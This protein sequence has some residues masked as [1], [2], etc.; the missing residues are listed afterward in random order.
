MVRERQEVARYL[1]KRGCKTDILMAAALGDIE[2]VREHLDTDPKC[3]G[4]NVSERYFTKRDPRAGGTIYIWCLGWNKTAHLVAR[5]F[6]HEEIFGLLM[7]RSP[8]ELKLA[9]ACELGD[10]A[11]F[12]SLMQSR[13]RLVETLSANE[14][15]K[16][17]NAAQS[18][19]TQTVRLMTTTE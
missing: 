4:M 3:I 9:L 6:G 12:N 1:V 14:Y 19:N 11:L 7:D 10:E 13:S 16:I 2:L 17:A 15:R 5:E 8:M 18:N